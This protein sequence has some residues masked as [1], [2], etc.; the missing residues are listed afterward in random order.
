MILHVALFKFR[1]STQEFEDD[2]QKMLKSGFNSLPGIQASVASY[3][4]SSILNKAM[5]LEQIV[6]PDKSHGYTHCEVIIA[7]DLTALKG[8]LHSDAHVKVW[9]P[10]IK[11]NLESIIV[12]DT[13]LIIPYPFTVPNCNEAL[14]RIV[15]FKLPS[16]DAT[17]TEQLA[18]LIEKEFN[19]IAGI[20]ASFAAC[21]ADNL[22]KNQLLEALSW[23][24]KSHGYTHCKLLV[25]NS[26]D[27]LKDFSHSD[28]LSKV[29]IPAIEKKLE[30]YLIFDTPLNSIHSSTS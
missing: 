23:P 13:P 28:A 1:E 25:A 26:L 15:F 17:E 19:A 22:D 10:A 14:I 21:G 9:I 7:E 18:R 6:V 4:S 12:M 11:D 2:L 27:A 8:F 30:D 16:V 20:T 3:G 5:F 24:D 29:W